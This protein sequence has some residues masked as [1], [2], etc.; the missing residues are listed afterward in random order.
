VHQ[1]FIFLVVSGFGFA[2]LLFA[3]L[4]DIGF[5]TV[6]NWVSLA[7]LICGVI[8]RL[9]NGNLLIGL[10]V[11]AAFFL[12]TFLLWRFGL[13]GGGDV[14]LLTAASLFLTPSHAP[15]LLSGTAVVGGVLA[16][17]YFLAGWAV[18]R[19]TRQRPKGFLLR[20]LRC[21]QWRLRRRGP[22]PYAAA[23]A[24]GGVL[25]TLAS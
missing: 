4:H 7:L 8:L 2:A 6:P 14:K 3:A 1:S 10:G 21:E 17:I 5:R 13:M 12:M 19:P 23:I 22:L 11:S 9:Q 25:A 20:V 16:L 15:M 18:P 24:A